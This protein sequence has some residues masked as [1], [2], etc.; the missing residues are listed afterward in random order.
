MAIPPGH[1]GLLCPGQD[2]PSMPVHCSPVPPWSAVWWRQITS[3]LRRG[4]IPCADAQ[5]PCALCR[6]GRDSFAWKEP[7]QGQGASRGS[8]WS[9]ARIQGGIRDALPRGGPSRGEN[10]REA[11]QAWRAWSLAES[12]AASAMSSRGEVPREARQAWRAWSLAGSEAA[13]VMS[14]RGEVPREGKTLARLARL[15]E[16]GP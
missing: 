14:S 5:S 1:H 10:P 11:R 6:G 7:S 9:L 16:P 2:T 3:H 12:E 15:G 8:A 4:A 13:S